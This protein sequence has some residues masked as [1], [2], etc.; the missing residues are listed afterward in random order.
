[1]LHYIKMSDLENCLGTIIE[2]FHKYS[3][4]EGDKYKL[5]KTE[6]KELLTNEFPTLTEVIHLQTLI[7]LFFKLYFDLR[8]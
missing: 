7:K 4:K 8:F 6:L 3:S 2:V 1:M 5:K